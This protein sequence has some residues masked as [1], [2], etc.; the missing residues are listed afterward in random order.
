MTNV[1]RPLPSTELAELNKPIM[2]EI[3]V[4]SQGIEFLTIHI[5]NLETALEHAPPE[6][7]DPTFLESYKKGI[8]KIST[9]LVT[10][11]QRCSEAKTALKNLQIQLQH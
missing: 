4:L 6:G 11:K 3:R 2:G 1:G 5:E 10:A 7:L 8:A 9:S